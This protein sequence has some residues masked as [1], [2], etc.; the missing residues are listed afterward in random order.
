MFI[1]DNCSNSYQH[2]QS[3]CRHKKNCRS[4]I[5]SKEENNY[6]SRSVD[7]TDSISIPLTPHTYRM[8]SGSG[9]S[10]PKRKHSVSERTKRP[11]VARLLEKIG[12]EAEKSKRQYQMRV[13]LKN[14][15][16][17]RRIVILIN[18]ITR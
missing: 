15:Y 7:D 1:C 12:D 14:Q 13:Q 4:T 11:S 5:S 3:L 8:D 6:S 17:T 16:I 9:F 2:R 18:R 10:V